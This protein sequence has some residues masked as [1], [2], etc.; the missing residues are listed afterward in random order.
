VATTVT[1]DALVLGAGIIGAACA[2]RLAERG[3]RVRVLER[4]G[5]LGEGSTGRSGAGVRVQFSEAVNVRLS[6]ESIQEYRTF[7]ERYGAESGYV[8]NGYLFLVPEP[9]WEAHLAGVAVQR[10]VG[11]PVEVLSPGAAQGLVPFI[12]EGVAGCTYGPADGYI[13][14]VAVLRVY[15]RE[16]ERRGAQLHLGAA[17]QQIARTA[18][19]WR[20][21]APAGTFEA[22]LIVNATGAWAGAVA[23]LAGLDVPVTPLKR[24]VYRTRGGNGGRGGASSYPL[25]VD[26]ASNFWLRGH[27]ETLLFALSNPHQAPGFDEGMDWGWLKTVRR[28]GGARFPWLS[29][30]PVDRKGSFWGYYEMTPDASPILGAMSGAP[31]W[32]NACGFSGHG[33]QQAAAVGRVIAAEAVGERP[34]IPVDDLRVE[35]FSGP[36]TRLERHIV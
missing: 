24:C 12:P 33:V 34:C 19:G 26:V 8:P 30:L 11:A 9:L 15:L 13:D 31:G 18:S 32:L 29:A 7:R 21:S 6:W 10:S 23:R 14:P 4:E 36:V 17:A 20:V 22:P 5:A 3:L 25:T 16:A 35:R 28:V 2:F 27:G 1:A